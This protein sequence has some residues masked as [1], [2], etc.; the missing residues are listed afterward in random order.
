MS[1]EYV[2]RQAVKAQGNRRMRIL[3][4]E[5]NGFERS[6]ER[7]MLWKHGREV[8]SFPNPAACPLYHSAICTCH[9]PEVCADAIVTDLDMPHLDGFS[10]VKQLLEKGC[11]IKNLAMLSESQDMAVLA[12][13]AAFGFSVFR[14]AEGI[15]ALLKWLQHIEIQIQTERRLIRWAEA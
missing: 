4:F 14:K 15:P 10:F 9:V 11:K 7:R 12:R 8:I 3:L 6:L 5:D 2:M 13:A 1:N